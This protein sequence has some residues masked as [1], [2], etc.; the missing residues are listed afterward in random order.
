[1][2][3]DMAR[4][5]D[6]WAGVD[7]EGSSCRGA[8]KGWYKHGVCLED[9][10]QRDGG[11]IGTLTEEITREAAARPLGAYFRVNHKDLVAM[12]AAITE[13][14]ILYASASVHSGWMNVSKDGR[15]HYQTDILGGHAFAIVAYDDEGFWVQNSWGP[16]WGRD[17]FCH[18]RYDDWLANG[19]DVWVARLAVPVELGKTPGTTATVKSSAIRNQG[20][21]FSDIRPH[22]IGIKNDG[23]L[24]ERGDIGTTAETV[25]E[26]LLQDFPRITKNWKKKRLVL[27]AHGGLVSKDNA[28]QRVAEYREKMLEA[29]CYPLAFIWKTDYWTTLGNMLADAA[30]RRRPEGIIDNT[31]DF[32][33]DRLDDLLEPLARILT[34]K[35]NG[36]R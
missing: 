10:W 26:I 33:L 7:Y 32:M 11:K 14:G 29:E 22:V 18:L 24:D 1:M 2:L 23:L 25:R 12:H 6:E 15:I 3:Y 31:K 5:Y 20:F 28:L 13:V 17:R 34:E 9:Q 21:I 30:R 4:R 36:M 8:V 35:V 16:K 27:Y 19:T